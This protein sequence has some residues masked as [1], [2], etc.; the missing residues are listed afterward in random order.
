[1]ATYLKDI[2]G[3]EFDSLWDYASSIRPLN[4]SR[5][6]IPFIF[7]AGRPVRGSNNG[8]RLIYYKLDFGPK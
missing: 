4:D 3:I 5:D 2:R 6:I 1:M 8:Y 7:I